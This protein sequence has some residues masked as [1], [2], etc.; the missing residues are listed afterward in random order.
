[1]ATHS[2][3]LDRQVKVGEGEIWTA[4]ITPLFHP[5][6]VSDVCAKDKGV[7]IPLPDLLGFPPE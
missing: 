2:G 4:W 6:F 5:S 1:M 3:I 7:A